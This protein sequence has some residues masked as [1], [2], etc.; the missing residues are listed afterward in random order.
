MANRIF[1]IL[2]TSILLSSCIRG[3]LY[4]NTVT[5]YCT[6]MGG[7]RTKQKSGFSGQKQINIPRVPGARTVWSSNAIYDAAKAEGLNTIEYCD[8]KQFSILN[9]LYGTDE[10]IVYGR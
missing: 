1:V 5:P 7:V 9:G 4:T 10:I 3:Y 8:R 6:D 2:L